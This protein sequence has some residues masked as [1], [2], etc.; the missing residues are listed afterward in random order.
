LLAHEK[1]VANHLDLQSFGKR[2][3]FVFLSSI[4]SPSMPLSTL[5]AAPQAQPSKRRWTPKDRGKQRPLG[6]AALEDKIVQQV[7]YLHHV[8][9]PLPT[10]HF[11]L[12]TTYSNLNAAIG[13]IRVARRAGQYVAARLATANTSA[14]PPYEIGS[15]GLSPNR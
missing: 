11:P 6:I 7:V 13:S 5:H 2:P 8:L 3:E 15:S 10:S 14:A 12:P 1:G 4:P 9:G